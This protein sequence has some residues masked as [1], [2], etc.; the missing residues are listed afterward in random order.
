MSEGKLL[1]QAPAANRPRHSALRPAGPSG[2]K[3]MMSM[4][5]APRTTRARRVQRAGLRLLVPRFVVLLGAIAPGCF[6]PELVVEG[7]G[8]GGGGPDDL[9][10]AASGGA[11]SGGAGS[12]GDGLGG[13]GFGGGGPSGGSGGDG[14]GGDGAGGSPGGSGGDGSGGASSGGN[15]SGGAPLYGYY[16]SGAWQGYVGTFAELG[17]VSPDDFED[18]V[19]PPYCVSG[20]IPPDQLGAGKGGWTWNLNQEPVCMQANCGT[21]TSSAE[22]ILLTVDNLLDT[23]LRIQVQAPGGTDAETWCAPLPTTSGTMFVSWS[24]FDTTCGMP[25]GTAYNGEELASLQIFVPGP[26]AGGSTENFDFCVESV[27]EVD[28]PPPTCRLNNPPGIGSYMLMGQETAPVDRLGDTYVVQS[29]VLSAPGSQTI[30]GNGTAFAITS[31]DGSA[32]PA[33]GP[34]SFPS[35]FVGEVNGESSGTP[36]MPAQVGLLGD[37]PTAWAWTPPSGGN[38]FAIYQLGFAETADAASPDEVVHI[39]LGGNGVDPPGTLD[40]SMSIG[41]RAWEVYEPYAANDPIVAF[42][43]TTPPITAFE[44]A[45]GPFVDEAVTRGLSNSYFL[46][47]IAAGFRVWSGSVGASTDNFCVVVQ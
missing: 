45:L 27:E 5:R 7:T 43:A 47:E 13:D 34:F 4:K 40:G 24:E 9:G 30:T 26:G 16:E 37:L 46:M 8:S 11:A 42:R 14:S 33:G 35:V 20:A 31:Q 1:A 2:K 15:G 38:Y 25:G 32:N 3:R 44:E 6:L 17:T 19:G 18:T 28:E 23:D 12:G 41:G 39:I 10:G 36:G 21:V 29:R 22:G